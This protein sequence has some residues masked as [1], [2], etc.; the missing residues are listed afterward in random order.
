VP[1]HPVALAELGASLPMLLIRHA[2]H[3]LFVLVEVSLEPTP[4]VS[5]SMLESAGYLASVERFVDVNREVLTSS[6]LERIRGRRRERRGMLFLESPE[7]GCTARRGR[8]STG[9]RR[10]RP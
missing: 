7:N 5:I 6:S 3:D 1:A 2:R 8:F 4:G 10:G 9:A